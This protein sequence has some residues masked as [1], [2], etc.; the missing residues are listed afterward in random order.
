MDFT[1][2]LHPSIQ[3]KFSNYRKKVVFGT[4]VV[5][6]PRWGHNKIA[7]CGFEI[8]DLKLTKEWVGFLGV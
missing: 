4:A 5:V 2:D 6:K 8:F 7:N 1:F 3:R